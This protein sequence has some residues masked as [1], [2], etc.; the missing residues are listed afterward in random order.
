[1]RRH[2]PLITFLLAALTVWGVTT[3]SAT[4]GPIGFSGTDP[5]DF[6]DQPV[7][8]TSSPITVTITDTGDEA[9]VIDPSGVTI[10]GT[11]P[12]SFQTSNDGCS[13]TTVA[14]GGTCTVDVRFAPV[15]G[16]GAYSASLDVQ[17]STHSVTGSTGLAGNGTG[18]ASVTVSPDPFDF[19][20]RKVG[21]PAL[22]HQFTVTNNGNLV[23]SIPSGGVSV[24]GAGFTKG[25]DGCSSTTVIAGGSCTFTVLFDPAS[26][27]AKSGLASI[28]SSDPNSPTGVS[29]SGNGTVPVASLPGSVSFA[30]P[31]GVPQ[32]QTVTL[33]NTG[34]ATL[35]ISGIAD[36]AGD[37]EFAK[38]MVNSNCGGAT[39]APNGGSCNVVMIFTPSD[40]AS[41]SA[42]LTFNDDASTSPQT[43]Q[44]TGTTLIPGISSNPTSMGFEDIPVGR[45]SGPITATITNTGQADLHIASIAIGGLNNKSFRLGH[46]TCTQAP[47]A[48]G[49]TCTINVRFGPTKV[50]A[51][52]ATLLV[53]NDAGGTANTFSIALTG[54]GVSPASA[55]ALRAAAGCTDARLTWRNPD[56]TGF[57][58]VR[59]VR[60]PAH[61]PRGP[62]DGVIVKHTS[63]DAVTNTGLDQF[64]RY[65]YALYAVYRS[66]DG[67]H[68]VFSAATAAAIRTGR[69]C[70][71][72]N[73]SLISDLSPAVDWTSYSGAHYYAYILQRFGR[74]IL[75][76][77]PKHSQT[78]LPSSWK[79]DGQSKSIQHGGVYSF[80]LYAYT[81][82]RPRGFLI[83]QTVFTER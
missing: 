29:L 19:G 38:D 2:V 10:G 72:R 80:Y 34:D 51:R 18:S 4:V 58:G 40:T 25:T 78:T 15:N 59:V 28:T 35:V 6:G 11:N 57:R 43:V 49:G 50:G 83:G 79:F 14:A 39:L 65:Y 47:I 60:N 52:V 44:L 33:T 1:M 7:G 73:G 53:R 45:L 76:R 12:G 55:T 20:D 3:A 16:T 27:G 66:Y 41:K 67:S 23:L 32:T 36:L 48:Q 74:T 30:S 61:V 82:G 31:I 37:P 42:T 26:A 68:L 22:S 54:N 70:T 71:P 8:T 63:P 9:L 56:A 24:T 17:D 69:I 46:Q 77:Y 62:F 5:I 21:S 81:S 13:G 75:V 64:H